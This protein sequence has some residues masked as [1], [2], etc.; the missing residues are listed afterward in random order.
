MQSAS[1]KCLSALF[2]C[3]LCF[4]PFLYLSFH[5]FRIR[6]FFHGQ[7]LWVDFGLGKVRKSTV[8]LSNNSGSNLGPSEY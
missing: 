4:R 6:E 8:S 3:L 5:I 2:V 7:K 1:G